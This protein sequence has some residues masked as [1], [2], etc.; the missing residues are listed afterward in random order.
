[1]DMFVKDKR[2]YNAMHH[3]CMHEQVNIVDQCNIYII[4]PSATSLHAI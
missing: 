1:M 4:L 3:A 2:G